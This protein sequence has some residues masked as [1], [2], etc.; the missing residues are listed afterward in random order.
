VRSNLDLRIAEARIREAR[1][2][3]AVVASGAWPT[4]DTSGS[5]TRSRTS[6]NALGIPSQSGG[7]GTSGGSGFKLERDLFTAGFDAN[8]E[9]DVFGGVRRSVEAADATIAATE[10]NRRDVLVSLLGEVARNYIDLRAAQR[11]LAVARANLK[12][13]KD[14]LDLTRV[15]FDAGLASDLDVARAEAQLNTTASQIPTLESELKGAAYSLDLLLGLSPGALWQELEKEIAIPQLPAE[16]LVGLPSDLLRRRPDIRVAERRLAAATA[17]VGSAIADLFPKFFLIGDLGLQSISASD[18]FSRGSR[19]WSIG[20]SISWPVF[21]AGRIRANIEIRNA[22][23]EQALTEY[24][25]TVLAALGDVEKS[26][27]NYAK[28]Q[29]RY[30]TLNDAVAANRRAVAMAQELYIR[31]LNDYLNVLDTQRELYLTESDLAQSEA[32]MASNLVA[33]YKALGG[34]W[35]VN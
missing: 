1:A 30:R 3:R 26:L 27:V 17:Q 20:P 10:Y 16:V 11:R 4:V 19:Y 21:D 31:G 2:S 24:E 5:Y 13:Q 29:V 8:W 25:K 35:E 28:E 7:G 6:E 14:S 34:G 9:I 18:W 22:Q 12:T 33:L 32:T 23:Q 15:R